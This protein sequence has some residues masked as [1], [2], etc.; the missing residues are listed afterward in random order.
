MPWLHNYSAVSHSLGLTAMVAALP[1]FFLFWALAYKR[2]K[3]YV[4]ASLTLLL[5]LLVAT[6]A[7]G[8]P[9]RAALS[10]SVLGMASGLWPIGWIILTAVFFYNL[11]VEGGQS[12]IIQSSISSLSKDRRLQA[13]L[14]AFCFSAF[15]EGVAG[16]G[17]PVAVA[18]AM[19]IGLGF[20]PL[21]AAVVCLVANTAPVPFGPVGV[22]T[23][24]MISV[25]NLDG[26]AITRTIGSDMA[27]L[28]LLIP[29]LVLV[30]IS[31]FKRTVDVWPAALVAGFSYAVT[32]FLVSHYLGVEL[33]AI[34]SAFVSMV[35]LIVFLKFWRPKQI[36]QFAYDSDN[37]TQ[38]KT[39]YSR[40][41]VLMAWSPYLLLMSMMSFWGTP[42]L[43]RFVEN[44]LH[45]VLNIPQW[46]GLD[47]IVYRTAPIVNVPT[48]YPASYRWN[49]LT[50]PG[51]AM[52]I[53]AVATMAILRISPSR[54]LKVFRAT[55][56]EVEFAL[57]TLAAVVGI[58]YLANYSG[59]SYTLGLA[60]ASYAG[61]L[62]PVFSP[63]IGWLGVF[64]T[65]SVTSSAALFG[66]LQQVTATQTG[67]NPVLTT[68]ANIFGGVAGK[69]ISPQSIAIACAATGLIGRETDIFRNTIK[70]SLALLGLVVVIVLLEAWVVPGAIPGDPGARMQRLALLH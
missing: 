61:K 51:T 5:M 9:G 54:G 37:S 8:M 63:V 35:C 44:K 20:K 6:T 18:A 31:G 66:K 4:A 34:I 69:L 52:L 53:C 26:A 33:P 23:S 28:A 39:S 62:F 60:C 40:R 14:I 17:A 3:G 30:V 27:I 70:Y 56:K 22:P 1:I 58:G 59:M 15:L 49:F 68:S 36:W 45:W 55:C 32:C 13:L 38:T 64:L 10:A 46:P 24:M 7:Y 12:E 25:T 19:L 16:E 21:P 48:M 11:T 41:Q 29:L 47:G 43:T 50:A 42:A 57:V 2:M 65:G 67:M